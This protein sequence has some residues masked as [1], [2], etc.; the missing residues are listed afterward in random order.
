M[1]FLPDSSR[2]VLVVHPGSLGDVL[3]SLPT[4]CAIRQLWPSRGLTLAARGEIGGFLQQCREIDQSLSLDGAA[5]S[6]LWTLGGN[7]PAE[8]RRLFEQCDAAVAWLARGQEEMTTLFTSAGIGDVRIGSPHGAGLRSVHQAERY[9]EAVR[10]GIQ[11]DSADCRLALPES[12][13]KEGARLLAKQGVDPS[14]VVVIVHPGSGSRHKCLPPS[15]LCEVIS[16]AAE[17]GWRPVMVGGPADGNLV[18]LVQEGL[19][20][21]VSTVTNLPLSAVA[22]LLTHATAYL[23][24][25]SGLTHLAALL[26]VPTIAMFGPTD[27]TRWAPR[28]WNVQVLRGTDCLC[29]G[30]EAVADCVEKPCL[31]ISCSDLIKACEYAIYRGENQPHVSPCQ[32]PSACSDKSRCAKVAS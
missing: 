23:G 1:S 25:D 4:L 16:A 19:T 27:P 31:S 30:W 3:L 12:M 13:V 8:L 29:R 6:S 2:H 7:V 20:K 32:A 18:A 11:P 9:G 22:G 24:H 5:W 15:R 26:G 28:G 17:R 10:I 21:P 14:S